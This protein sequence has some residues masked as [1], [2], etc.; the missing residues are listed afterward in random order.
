[1]RIRRLFANFYCTH[2]YFFERHAELDNAYSWFFVLMN[3]AILHFSSLHP[4]HR[5]KWNLH[6]FEHSKRIHDITGRVRE[7][8]WV[9]P[10]V[11]I[12]VNLLSQLLESSAHTNC[13]LSASFFTSAIKSW[14]CPIV[15][16]YV[17]VS[18]DFKPM[19]FKRRANV[20]STNTEQHTVV[21]DRRTKT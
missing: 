11:S 20:Q 21:A 19:V 3:L 6:N 9:L 16:V 15:Y 14:Q 10:P 5:P 17:H 13:R 4:T 8:H 1:M 2:T 18:M 12:L 7:A